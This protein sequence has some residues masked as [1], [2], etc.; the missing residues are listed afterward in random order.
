MN[1][2][3]EQRLRF[4]GN[5]PTLPA[6][7][8]RIIELAND[9]E[10][11]L[12][13]VA[14]VIAL[15]PALVAKLFRAA[16]S[17]LYGLRRK[18]TN[19][20]QILNLLGLQGT[21]ALALGFSLVATAR[22]AA[23]IP[24]DTEQF[25]RRSLLV[26]TAGRVISE[27]L[28]MDNLEEAFLAGLLH[29]I[30][31]LALALMLPDQYG[32]MLRATAD[33]QGGS[34]STMLDCERLAQIEE[35]RLGADHPQVGAWLLRH[36]G[37]PDSLCDAVA[38]SLRPTNVDA[39]GRQRQL[40]ECVALAVRIADIW[41]RPGYWQSSPKIAEL[42]RQWFGLESKDYLEILEA[43]GTKF[44][45]IAALFQIRALDAAEV[46]G[47]LEQAREILT[48]RST[49]SWPDAGGP[50]RASKDEGRAAS[51][52]EP[53]CP[54]PTDVAPQPDRKP[55]TATPPE[56]S[57]LIDP[58]TGLFRRQYLDLFLQQELVNAKDHGW[59]LSVALLD[60]DHGKQLSDTHGR[61]V[62]DQVLIAL[63]R[64]LGNNIRRSDALIRYGDD[65]F[66]LLLPASGVEAARYLL[67]R[68]LAL[69][70]DWALLLEDGKRLY[71]TVSAG[72]AT[73]PD[74]GLANCAS[75]EQL[76]RAADRA[77]YIAKRAGRD[78]LAV[79]G[80]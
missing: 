56:Q 21:L 42:A 8:I 61:K 33:R 80:E 53:S 38:G 27:R 18:A 60:L 22:N 45:E 59:P 34:G 32:A 58:L 40:V 70:R 76:L 7:A 19:L 71:L 79:Y 20:R 30:G 12:N 69:I 9:P 15:D 11:D 43:I 26:A 64:L 57:P 75:S 13:E 73:Y 31:I 39:V 52:P 17:P 35:E 14:K 4:C 10:V 72:L 50:D 29:G 68:L 6:V 49:R 36:W 5:L 63:A 3:L 51:I 24:L 55:A 47:I 78:R 1:P 16:N 77:L 46:A 54:A 28:A 65:E 44:P 25:W 66:A 67:N 23:A 37:L 62:G 48:L 41:M 74:T 2:E